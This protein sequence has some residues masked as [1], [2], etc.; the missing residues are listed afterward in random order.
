MLIAG[1]NELSANIKIV[2]ELNVFPVPDG[3]TGFKMLKTVEGVIKNIPAI[4]NA[5]VSELASSFS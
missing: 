2:N 5:S 4:E 3:D 1:A